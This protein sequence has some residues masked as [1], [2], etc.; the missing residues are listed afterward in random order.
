MACPP[1]SLV[2]DP[3]ISWFWPFMVIELITV[4]FA[5]D[6]GDSLK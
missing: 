1:F 4:S 2:I 5:L 3:C 6:C